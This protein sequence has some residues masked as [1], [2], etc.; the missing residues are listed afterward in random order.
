LTD[1][2]PLTPETTKQRVE[3]AIVAELAS[4]QHRFGAFNSPHEGYAVILEE[5]DELCDELPGLAS[6]VAA[7]W[8]AVKGND[9]EYA[10]SVVDDVAYHAE[11]VAAEAIQVAAMAR[12][13][14][15]D[16]AADGAA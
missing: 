6:A 15:I 2:I 1:I 14:T 13:F 16:L 9:R 12:R 7:V 8:A 11:R 3:D 4:A 10:V 5:H